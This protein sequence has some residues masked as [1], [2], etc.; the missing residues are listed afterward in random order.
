MHEAIVWP[1]GYTWSPFVS[2]ATAWSI[3]LQERDESIE[4]IPTRERE[5]TPRYACIY[6]KGIHVGFL[7]IWYDNFLVVASSE[8]ARN[9]IASLIKR[10]SDR[11]NASI[12]ESIMSHNEVTYGGIDFSINGGW[13]HSK[14]NLWDPWPPSIAP[15]DLTARQ[16]AHFLG[17]FAR[18]WYVS[19]TPNQGTFAFIQCARN[20][21]RRMAQSSSWDKPQQWN[22]HEVELWKE[23]QE[24]YETIRTDDT[25]KFRTLKKASE[26]APDFWAA[27]DATPSLGAWVTWK[28]DE[29]LSITGRSVWRWDCTISS[30]AED[31]M[32]NILEI[33]AALSVINQWMAQD[34]ADQTMVIAIDNT[35][36]ARAIR[37]GYY[38][39]DPI[40]NLELV[41]MTLTAQ[42]KNITIWPVWV[43]S[44]DQPADPLTR[45]RE[46][47]GERLRRGME[48]ME[49]ELSESERLV[50]ERDREVWY[51]RGTRI[52]FA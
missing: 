51:T 34:V 28:N 50:D 29:Q 13:K 36:A 26:I 45:G 8:Q 11:C 17:I 27:S 48:R 9:D 14:K 2:Q 42:T 39:W 47:D 32:I 22:D 38:G 20:L 3:I 12:K 49:K 30:E 16:L 21:G 4:I 7:T 46:I 10:A 43:P 15:S 35:T 25:V 1:Q 24:R 23:V 18:D 6:Q 19:G 33:R 41:E 52:H 40:V 44:E 5:S 37:S 31:Q